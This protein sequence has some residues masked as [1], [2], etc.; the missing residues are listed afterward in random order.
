MLFNVSTPPPIS[1]PP[2]LPPRLP[3]TLP[4]PHL[5]RSQNA[6][7]NLPETPIEDLPIDKFISLM[8]INVTAGVLCTKYAVRLM[9]AQEPRGGRI[10]NNGS[11]AAYSPRPGGSCLF[12]L[13]SLPGCPIGK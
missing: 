1:Y 4:P 12:L 7:I 2:Y 9:K 3:L 8:S 11:I 10:I 5:P 13:F 6:G